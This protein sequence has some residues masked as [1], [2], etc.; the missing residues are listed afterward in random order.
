MFD[1]STVSN[2]SELGFST[3]R[4][5]NLIKV[6]QSEVD[7]GRL[8]GAV[9]L[10]ARRGRVLLHEALGHQDPATGKSMALDS[11]FRIYSMTKP[12]VSVATMVM[13][14]RGQL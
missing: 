10:I 11:I 3:E 6:L 5:L 12:V 8:P 14:E 9:A 2:P 7:K 1:T 13:M 4:T